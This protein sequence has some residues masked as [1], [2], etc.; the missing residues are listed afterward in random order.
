MPLDIRLSA[1]LHDIGKPATRKW[2]KEKKDYTFYG[3]EVVGA[4]MA[5]KILTDLKFSHETV[6]KVVKLVRWHM[7]FSDTEQITHS[8]VRRM[9]SN[10]GKENIWDLM[11]LRMCDRIGTGRPKEDPYRLRKYMSLIEEV[12]ADPTDVSML[13]IDGND[14][15][16]ELHMKP[17]PVI[18]KILHILLEMCIEDPK[19]NEKTSLLDSAKAVLKKTEREIDDLYLKALH[20]KEEE[21][22]QKIKKIRDSH[23]VI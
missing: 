22:Q 9:I 12:L 3:H 15:M 20:T 8:A 14:L 21:N 7:F 16:I 18:G 23:R 19:I 13:K 11:D 17:G 2:L 6:E 10:V 1:L 4:K 5:K